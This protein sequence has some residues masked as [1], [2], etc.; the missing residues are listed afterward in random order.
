MYV[1]LFRLSW[2]R[3]FTEIGITAAFWSAKLEEDKQ[4]T[5]TTTD[6]QSTEV[7]SEPR[8]FSAVENET[9]NEGA[10]VVSVSPEILS[11]EGLLQLFLDLSSVPGEDAHT[12]A[13]THKWT[14][15]KSHTLTH[16]R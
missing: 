4:K 3:Y 9:E 11:R 2:S 7:E 10:G 15:Y 8:P 5:T 16:R 12:H 1:Y 13:H 14:R 6:C